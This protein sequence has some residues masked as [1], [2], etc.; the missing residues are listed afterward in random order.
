MFVY[1][2]DIRLPAGPLSC[3]AHSS[4]YFHWSNWLWQIYS[5]HIACRQVQPRRRLARV[6]YNIAS[7]SPPSFVTCFSFFPV[8]VNYYSPFCLHVLFSVFQA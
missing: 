7:D 4:C 3:T 1:S 8:S 2:N 6:L 5:G